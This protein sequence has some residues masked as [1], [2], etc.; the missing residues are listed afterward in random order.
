MVVSMPSNAHRR[1]YLEGVA[2]VRGDASAQRLRADAW[3][4]MQGRV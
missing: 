3:A 1:G 4:M 2:K